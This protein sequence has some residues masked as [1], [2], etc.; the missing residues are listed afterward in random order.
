MLIYVSG[1]YSA[2]SIKECEDNTY[3]A[4]DIGLELQS[5]GHQVIIPHLSHWQ[6]L[7]A[8]EKGI[9]IPYDYWIDVDLKMIGICDALFYIKQSKG[10]DIELAKAKELGLK[11][12]Y[13]LDEVTKLSEVD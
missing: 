12:F 1:P 9:K 4:I 11:I 13:S 8:K 7:R 6:D 10:A 3:R 5:K 2:N